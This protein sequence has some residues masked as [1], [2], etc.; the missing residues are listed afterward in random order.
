[1]PLD[2]GGDADEL[3]TVDGVACQRGGSHDAGDDAG[4]AGTQAAGDGHVGLNVDSDGEGRLAPGGQSIDKAHIDQV[5]LVLKLLGAARDGELV[6]T[7]KGKVRVEADG[8]A[9]GVVADA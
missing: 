7:L 9:E 1:M 5:I 4:G 8:H 6:G 3:G 2:F